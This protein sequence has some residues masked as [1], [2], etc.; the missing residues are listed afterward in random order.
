MEM[1]GPLPSWSWL[2]WRRRRKRPSE[3]RGKTRP[4]E[5]HRWRITLIKGTPAK[6]LGYVHAP[7]EKTA[8]ARAAEDYD[9][10][11]R[12]IDRLVATPE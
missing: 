1:R 3:S 9:V 6:F 10:S 2:H 11:D 7:D 8:I 4:Q 5:S 12:L